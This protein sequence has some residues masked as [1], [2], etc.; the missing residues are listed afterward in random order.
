MEISPQEAQ[1]AQRLKD[2]CDQRG[3]EIEVEQ[4]APIFH[5]LGLFY[6]KLSPDKIS[7]IQSS[8]L[9]VAARIRQPDNDDFKRDLRE[10]C[11]HV[12]TLASSLRKSQGLEQIALDLADKLK[13]MREEAEKSLA[14]LE[15]IP[16]S[17]ADEQLQK[18]YDA[19]IRDVRLIQN[20][21]AQ[22]YVESMAYVS[23]RCIDTLGN[24]PCRYALV[25]MGS[26]ARKEISPYSDFEHVIVLEDKIKQDTQYEKIL[27]YFR[28]FTVIFQIILVNLGETIIPSVAIPSLN[29]VTVPGGDWFFDGTTKRGV[30]FDGLMPHACKM[31]LGRTKKTTKKPWTTELIKTVSDMLQYLDSAEILKNGYHLGDILTRICFVSGDE[32][33]YRD[34]SDGVQLSLH[35]NQTSNAVEMMTQLNDDLKNFDTFVSLS[36]LQGSGTCNVKRVVYRS[37]TLFIAALGRIYDVN[38]ASC[39]DIVEVLYERNMTNEYTARHLN[40]AVALACEVRLKVYMRKRCQD[41]C[42]GREGYYS[43]SDNKII[44]DLVSVIGK[45]C[46]VDYFVTAHLLQMSLRSSD[47][48]R[49]LD[50]K[51]CRSTSVKFN[52]LHYLGFDSEMLAEWEQMGNL[53]Q[54]TPPDDEHS[55]R[56]FVAKIYEKNREL[57]KALPMFEWL[58]QQENIDDDTKVHVII[59]RAWAYRDTGRYEEGMKYVKESKNT[60]ENLKISEAKK[61]IELAWLANTLASC[62]C[63]LENFELALDIYKRE[64]LYYDDDRISY[65]DRRRARCLLDTAKCALK[66]GL[67]DE[68]I[69]SANEALEIRTKEKTSVSSIC[70]CRALLGKCYEKQGNYAEAAAQFSAEFE[71]RSEYVPTGLNENDNAI[72][73]AQENFKAAKEKIENVPVV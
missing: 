12:V 35:K 58:D 4:S 18:L 9:L 62:H 55:I 11:A 6:R 43:S 2:V 21:I 1:L 68:A 33:L 13:R 57:D 69:R 46:L 15:I 41:D 66:L 50:D 26:L 36:G 51:L 30:S 44:N 8:V 25:G 16:Y 31:P 63:H 27:E 37:T 56:F 28:W 34:F 20:K 5:K 48:L 40:L 54:Q 17:V 29:D 59:S 64:L 3:R 60:I 19:K 61:K 22:S 70:D 71:M 39:F 72:K 38:N 10:L 45:R 14:G 52:I 32:R 53:P 42:V 24:P 47:P 67:F 73:Q 23:T 7:L 65:R 49:E